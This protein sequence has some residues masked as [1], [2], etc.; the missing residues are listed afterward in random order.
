MATFLFDKIIF[1]PVKSRRLGISLGINLLPTDTKICNFDCIYCECGWTDKL[2]SK[3]SVLPSRNQVKEALSGKLLEMK[4]NAE[5]PD[6]ITFAGNGE[7]TMHPEFEGIIDDTIKLRN[8]LCPAA[9][10]AVLSNST[11]IHKPSVSR[12]LQKV[13]QNILK[14]DTVNENTFRL[15]NKAAR[16]IELK[17]IIE[18]LQAFKGKMIIQTLFLKGDFGGEKFDNSSE[19]ELNGLIIAFNQIQPEKIMIYTFERDTP[20][21]GIYK[22]PLS[23]LQKIAKRLEKEGFLVEVSA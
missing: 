17:K 14:L 11:L 6:V 2:K 5:S 7:P 9:G 4:E 21:K 15:I 22:I 13:D 19:E 20:A 8:K 23:G 3:T 18:V 12:A 10:I 1:G 16:G